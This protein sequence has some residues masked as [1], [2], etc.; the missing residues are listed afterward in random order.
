[1]MIERTP[2]HNIDAALMTSP[3]SK[4][5]SKLLQVKV[6]PVCAGIPNTKERSHSPDGVKTPQYKS[7][8][9]KS[10]IVNKQFRQK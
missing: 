4:T 8:V 5:K 7:P 9:R 3:L 6:Y 1:M 10:A 2:Y